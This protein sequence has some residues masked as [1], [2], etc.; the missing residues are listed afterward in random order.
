MSINNILPSFSL[1]LHLLSLSTYYRISGHSKLV[2]PLTNKGQ[3]QLLPE[4][5]GG[6][7]GASPRL[8]T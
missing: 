8:E 1:V 4:V 7:G 5:V 6:C 2:W 3:D